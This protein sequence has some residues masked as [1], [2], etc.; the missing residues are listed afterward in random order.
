MDKRGE[1]TAELA[2]GAERSWWGE[3]EEGVTWLP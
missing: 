2:E 3:E 1:F